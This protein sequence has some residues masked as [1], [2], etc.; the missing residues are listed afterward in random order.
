MWPPGPHAVLCLGCSAPAP[1]ASWPPA[2]VRRPS[3]RS[4]PTWVVML[5]TQVI[6]ADGYTKDAPFC[7]ELVLC[8]RAIGVRGYNS[9]TE[10]SC[11]QPPVCLHPHPPDH[12]PHPTGVRADPVHPLEVDFCRKNKLFL[13]G[14]T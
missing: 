9:G 12:E 1:T 5:W 4:A 11:P 10:C 8:H 7:N 2:H 3:R 6:P 13:G 14:M